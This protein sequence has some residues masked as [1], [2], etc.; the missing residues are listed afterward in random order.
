MA[1]HHL[2]CDNEVSHA[3]NGMHT[4]LKK[5]SKMKYLYSWKMYKQVLYVNLYL[6]E[7]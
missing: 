6:P 5:V 7:Q 3:T 1:R 4:K 2:R